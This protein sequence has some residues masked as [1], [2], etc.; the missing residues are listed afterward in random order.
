MSQLRH[1]TNEWLNRRP[2]KRFPLSLRQLFPQA[3]FVDCV[4]ILVSEIADH[5]DDCRADVMFA[6]CSGTRSDGRQFVSEAIR[7][8][9]TSLL[10]EQPLPDVLIPQC[11]VP[12]V[13]AAY[14]EL[15]ESMHNRPSQ[16]LSTIG[17]TGT[18]GKTTTSWLIRT[19]LQ[20]AN[21]RCGLLGTVENYDGVRSEPS[22]MTTSDSRIVSR[23]L[24]GMVQNDCSHAV[25]E[26][27]SHALHQ[28][29]AA[30]AKLDAAVVTNLTQ[31]HFDY[32]GNW[33]AYRDCKQRI[34]D[35]L[36]P[37]GVVVLNADDP[38]VLAMADS[39]AANDSLT[40]NDSFT[41]DDRATE[42]QTIVTFG[43]ADTS[44]SADTKKDSRSVDVVAHNIRESLTG[45]RWELELFGERI[46][47]ESSLIGQHNVAN[48][49]AAAAVASQFGLS[50]EEIAVGIQTL[51]SVRGRFER[52]D[53]GQDFSV[54]I[55]YAHTDDA[56]RHCIRSLR[57]ITPRQIV[58]LC[59]A[60]GDRDRTKRPLI[61]TAAA[62]ADVVV[63]AG[64]NPRTERPEDI[65]DDILTGYPKSAATPYIETEREAA[66]RLAI[67][68]A[69]PGDSVLISGKGH[70]VFQIIGTER[71]PL[72][73]AE[74]ARDALTKRLA[75]A[76][77][78]HQLE[79]HPLEHLDSTRI[80]A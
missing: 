79:R 33:D 20:A 75:S 41:A 30:G 63:F 27:S 6:V 19:M 64:D 54:F 68:L 40:A 51:K 43:F 15:C 61:G 35:R 57:K 55:D 66:I 78:Q 45:S 9:A 25:M 17:V 8:G 12:N 52:I 31:D 1:E 36:K 42:Q 2:C 21:R 72:D 53:L 26:L 76:D 38:Q 49:L 70:E 80:P 77:S 69:E 44:G 13:R 50:I 4:D 28:N 60:G 56:L 65:I 58:C 47:I 74:I 11:V 16:Q 48:C 37:N 67:Q 14:A 39:F 23:W 18:N 3:S 24:D 59:G 10:L 73:D 29:R 71:V 62:E 5:T 32:H 34:F 7:L 22:L 46:E